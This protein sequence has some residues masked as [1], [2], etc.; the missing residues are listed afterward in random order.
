MSLQELAIQNSPQM[1]GVNSLINTIK[2][3]TNPTGMITQMANSNP[4]IQQVQQVAKQYGGYEQA[5]RAIAQQRGI[6]L[7]SIFNQLG[8]SL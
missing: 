3:A 8:G 2:S 5:V 1:S 4:M 7:Q 6:D